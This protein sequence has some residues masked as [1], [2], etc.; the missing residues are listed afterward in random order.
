[1]RW[2]KQRRAM[3]PA[4][5][6]Q[7]ISAYARTMV[8]STQCMLS[9]WRGGEARDLYRD[10][11]QLTLEIVTRCLFGEAIAERDASDIAY[12]VTSALSD[13][14]KR[15]GSPLFLIPDSVPLPGHMTYLKAA[16]RL[17]EVVY[18]IISQA[19]ARPPQP[20][21]LLSQL[22]ACV[23]DEGHSMSDRQL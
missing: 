23:D 19:R 13:F 6:R 7:Y 14:E 20:D 21:T 5:H 4:F 10:L 11:S 1:E 9:E 17:D 15:I 3:Q 8:E 22:M 12:C 16:R 18:S 2:L